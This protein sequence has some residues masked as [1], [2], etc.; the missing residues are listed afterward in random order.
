[1]YLSN[2][3]QIKLF[4]KILS[5]KTDIDFHIKRQ[6]RDFNE[7]VSIL[8]SVESIRFTGFKNLFSADS[9][10]Y[11]A[12]EDLTGTNAPE[13]FF[14]EAKYKKASIIDFIRNLHKSRQEQK[15]DKLIICGLD[16]SGLETIYNVDTFVNQIS[17]NC[18]RNNEGIFDH[19]AIKTELLK[20]IE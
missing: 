20:R 5:E 11:K 17:I 3:Q 4:S 8:K 1:L 6:F 12:I 13:S 7:F 14:I 16:E 9:K 2:S 18:E 19:N 15:L 10:Q